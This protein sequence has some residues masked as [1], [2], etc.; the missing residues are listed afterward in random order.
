MS[1]K[2]E[3]MKQGQ[4][5]VKGEFKKVVNDENQSTVSV[6]SLAEYMK[7][8]GDFKPLKHEI[9]AI[10]RRC[11]HDAD[12]TINFDEFKELF[13]SVVPLEQ[14]LKSSTGYDNNVNPSMTNTLEMRSDI[15][16][17]AMFNLEANAA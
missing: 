13:E 1:T 11:D 3:L 8:N 15:G 2:I 17:I 5:D 9:E 10:L 4:F 7:A 12:L 16:S 14:H 6:H